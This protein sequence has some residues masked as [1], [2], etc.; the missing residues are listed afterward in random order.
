VA[1][2]AAAVSPTLWLATLAMVP[3][4]FGAMAFMING[5]TMLQVT[6]RPEARGRVM[7]LYGVVFLGSTPIGSPIV[8]WVGEHLGPRVDLL[9][10]ASI[11]MGVGAAVLWARAR[12]RV[13]AERPAEAVAVTS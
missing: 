10:T 12:R 2:A 1:L 13:T 3:L 11:A 8:G 4:G 9:M 6:A 7:A 5:N